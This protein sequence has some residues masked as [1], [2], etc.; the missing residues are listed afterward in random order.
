MIRIA[1][2]TMPSAWRRLALLVAC[3][4]ALWSPVAAQSYLP[5][6]GDVLSCPPGSGGFQLGT[7]D[8][9][10]FPTVAQTPGEYTSWTARVAT[11]NYTGG[12]LRWLSFGLGDNSGLTASLD[13]RLALFL[14]LNHSLALLAQTVQV[15]VNPSGPQVLYAALP[16]PVTLT[17]GA[18]YV[19]AMTTAGYYFTQFTTGQT[20]AQPYAGFYSWQTGGLTTMTYWDNY[21]LD[22]RPLPF[23]PLS[24]LGCIA[25]EEQPQPFVTDAQ[26]YSFC[27]YTQ[28]SQPAPD[29]D[30]YSQQASSSLSV[31]SGL[32]ALS[33]T[34]GSSPSAR[35]TP[36]WP[37]R[38]RPPSLTAA[39]TLTRKATPSLPASRWAARPSLRP[40]ATCCTCQA[41]QPTST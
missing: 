30:D 5:Q 39:A 37:P 31:Y 25:D 18:E 1:H 20:A 11:G 21:S 35:T 24:A 8:I 16:F 34:S 3:L 38:P 7:D 19:V 28:Q 27:A 4:C 36:Y 32:L 26:L 2:Q 6:P 12:S 41:L 17:L 40:P 14:R 22:D 15:T 10:R 23:L 9:L 13:L 33:P 29:P